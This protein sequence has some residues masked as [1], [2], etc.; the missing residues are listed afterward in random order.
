M[1]CNQ[2]ITLL[3]IH[4]GSFKIFSPTNT[5]TLINDLKFLYKNSYS[6]I[7]EADT[8]ELTQRGYAYIKRILALEVKP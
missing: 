4:R 8:W 7:N 1:T 5:G 3:E 6:D 2:L